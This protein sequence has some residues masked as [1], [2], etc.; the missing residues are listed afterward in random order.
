MLFALGISFALV[1]GLCLTYVV[2]GVAPRIGMVSAP[3]V[4]RW[5]QKHTALLGGVAIY[6]AFLISFLIF[7]GRVPLALPVLAGGT[8]LFI[9][10]L[11]DD[12]VQ[13]KP[14]TKLVVQLIAA[15]MA[16]QFGIKLTW[17]S[18]EAVNDL[19]AIF[20]LVGITNAVNLL[21]NMDGLSGGVSA[22]ACVF[23]VIT[24]LMNGQVNEALLP[25]LL[26]AAVLG[27]LVFNFNPASIFMGDCGSMFLGFMLGGLSLLGAQGQ[28]RN[29]LAVLMTPALIL[30]IPIFDTCVVAVTRKLSGRPIS[31]GGRD[32]TSHRLVALGM[33]ERRAVVM[34]YIF[35]AASGLLA[36]MVRF[37]PV[38]AAFLSIASFA[39][40]ILFVGLYLGKV[41]VYESTEPAPGST[42]I[43]ALSGFWYK[44][45]VA[46]V[47]LDVFLVVIAY[48]GAYQLRWDGILP[49]EQFGIFLKTLPLVL[50]IQMVALLWGGVYQG[51]WKYISVGDVV[52][53][54]RSALGGAVGSGLLIFAMYQMQGPSRAVLIVN[55][56]L[57]FVL[58]A[59][60]RFSF[61]L[62]NAI[63]VHRNR[64][65]RPDARPV[66]IYGAGDGGE[67][68][69]R[70][71]LNNPMHLY[72]PVGFIDDDSRKEGKLIHGFRIF[73]SSKLP[74]L[75][76]QHGVNEVLVSSVKVSDSKLDCLRDLGLSLRRLSIRIE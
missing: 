32:H 13:I 61:R 31:Q 34:L 67:L 20:W 44:R 33:S 46:E 28:L 10:G 2:R 37:I 59:A 43:R 21:D 65:V 36:M 16:V 40:I 71:I 9:T 49:G 62:L 5:H 14:Y 53:I 6:F 70:E 23:L 76:H 41:K 35:A 73:S 24:L 8:L 74:E 39:L 60:S 25:A 69:I 58:I 18:Y 52:V 11:V 1:L 54:A 75:I 7:D 51:L 68:L 56:L 29:L 26:G 50:V 27:F 22:I 42:I 4:D 45:R 17:T 12:I 47:L 66:F 55:A 64:S 57:F 15:A 3:R 30:L 38:E 63:F 19:I 72:A 48:Y